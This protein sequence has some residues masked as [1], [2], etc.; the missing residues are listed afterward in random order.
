[1]LISIQNCNNID[2]GI[3]HVEE[4]TLNIKYAINGTGK[5]TIARA[6]TSM[7]KAEDLSYL[8]PF[9]YTHDHNDEYNPSVSID[10]TINRISVFDENYINLYAFKKDE[11]LENSFEVFVKTD[12]YEEHIQEIDKLV[13]DI[14]KVYAD[15]SEIEK[16]ILDLGLF[17]DSFGKTQNGYSKSGDLG[18]SLGKGNRLENVPAGLE[19]YAS[20]LKSSGTNIKWLKWQ[21]EGQAYLDI[22]EKCPYCVSTI[23]TPKETILRVSE[24]Y[25]VKYLTTLSRILEVLKSLSAYFSNETN[26]SIKVITENTNGIT[27]DQKNYLIRLKDEVSQLRD[28]LSDLRYIGFNS[29]K[30]VERVLDALNYKKINL[31]FY[32]Q[33]NSDYTKSKIDHI[34]TSL[35]CVIARAGQ[36]QGQIAQQK[37]EIEKTIKKHSTEINDFLLSAGYRYEVF[38]E[39]GEDDKHH[40]LLKFNGGVNGIMD[41]KNH[42]SYGERN[43]FALVL[44]MY[45]AIKQNSDFIILDD[46]ISSFDR[47]KKYAI[48]SMLFKGK[49]SLRGKTVLMLSHDFEPVIDT[50]Y[51][52]PHLFQP[53]ARASF[54]ANV[55]NVIEEKPIL[56]HNIKSCIDICKSNIINSTD[57]I[58]KLIYYRRL[59]EMQD[60]K[61]SAWQLVS[62]IFHKNRVIPMI[63]APGESDLREM[64]IDEINLF[65]EIVRRDIGGFDYYN[66]YQRTLNIRD[67]INLYEIS[68]SGYEKVQIYRILYDGDLETGSSLKKY[69]DET[70]HVQNDYLFQLNPREYKIVPQYI[71]DSCDDGINLLKEKW[72]L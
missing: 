57:M 13:S 30:D 62:N 49:S 23:S 37:K 60:D 45:Q 34:N 7:V 20:Y 4:G 1:M 63:K 33:L 51:N 10:T 53:V 59:L 42:L 27:E 9:K 55:E 47:N 40:L 64:T 38:I 65:T 26:A 18:K 15:D 46:P 70:F 36:L 5:S 8:K 56:K 66:V 52:L 61:D 68:K 54:I 71:L 25:D 14:Q 12:K 3:V 44:F 24:E 35:N 19:V 69:V 11:L 50:I 72:Q 67:M 58:H 43:A 22:S 41:V 29:L 17:I 2:K 32:P 31:E 6:L 16:L 28:K 48:I 39:K 21:T